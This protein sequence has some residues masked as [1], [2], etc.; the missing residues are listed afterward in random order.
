MDF[1][2]APGGTAHPPTRA[3]PVFKTIDNITAPYL[4]GLGT[5]VR[6]Y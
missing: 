2:V 6:I 4:P 1:H 5:G 3:D